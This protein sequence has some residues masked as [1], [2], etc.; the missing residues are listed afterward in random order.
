MFD[1]VNYLFLLQNTFA[2]ERFQD[3][4]AMPPMYEIE[5]PH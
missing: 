3:L 5:I 4:T 1:K 2:S